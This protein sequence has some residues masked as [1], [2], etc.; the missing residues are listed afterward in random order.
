[1]YHGYELEPAKVEK[2]M[3]GKK[4]RDTDERLKIEVRR[5]RAEGEQLRD[6]DPEQ[7]PVEPV[8]CAS[9]AGKF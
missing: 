2:G 7:L 5:S 9:G 4:R 3:N 6:R 8:P 1:M